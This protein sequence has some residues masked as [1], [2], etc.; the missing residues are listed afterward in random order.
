MPLTEMQS[1]QELRRQGSP[2]STGTPCAS[3]TTLRA[4]PSAQITTSICP[5]PVRPWA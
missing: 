3:I 1:G 4:S 2:G 5:A